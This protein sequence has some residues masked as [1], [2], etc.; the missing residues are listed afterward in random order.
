MKPGLYNSGGSRA[1][2]MFGGV[3]APFIFPDGY[4][5]AKVQWPANVPDSDEYLEKNMKGANVP[6]VIWKNSID[7]FSPDGRLLYSMESDGFAPEIGAIQHVDE[8]GT[9]YTARTTPN[10][11][12]YRYKLNVSES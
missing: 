10:P 6:E 2:R 3:N 1:I 12:I 4:M 9:I 11:V 7:F 8:F 5:M